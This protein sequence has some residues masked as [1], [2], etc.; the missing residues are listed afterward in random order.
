MPFVRIAATTT[1][2]VDRVGDERW[3]AVA[4]AAHM[5]TVADYI[6]LTWHC[7]ME[8]QVAGLAIVAGAAGQGSAALWGRFWKRK[9]DGGCL[10]LSLGSGGGEWGSWGW[11]WEWRGEDKHSVSVGGT[12]MD[13]LE[14]MRENV[15]V[16]N[17]VGS[18][19][20]IQNLTAASVLAS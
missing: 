7:C 2:L 20:R 9:V 15:H 13:E 11:L 10:N 12:D 18:V 8:S 16:G 14:L 5:R 1:L 3:R 17:A 19:G 6:T 4:L